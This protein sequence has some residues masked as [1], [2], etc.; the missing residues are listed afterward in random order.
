MI[1][2]KK[3]KSWI[4][5]N[6]NVLLIGKAGV[7]KSSIIKQCFEDNKIN[8]LYFSGATLDPWVD[9]VGIP[10]EKETTSTDG[11]KTS[12]IELVRPKYFEQDEVEAIFIDELNRSHAKVRNAVMELIQFKSINGKKFDKLR[13][14]W[15]AINPDTEKDEN[16]NNVYD[17]ERLDPA[18]KDRFQICYELPYQIDNSYFQSKYGS[19]GSVAT[20]WWTGLDSKTKD[21]VSPRRLEYVLEALNKNIDVRDVLPKQ[22]NVKT[23]IEQIQNGSYEEQFIKLLEEG[24]YEAIISN[25]S[26]VQH[27]SKKIFGNESVLTK[28]VFS[29]PAENFVAKFK[30]FSEQEKRNIETVFSKMISPSII[31]EPE[32]LEYVKNISE[33]IRRNSKKENGQLL[34]VLNNLIRSKSPKPPEGEKTESLSNSTQKMS[35]KDFKQINSFSNLISNANTTG[36]KVYHTRD[37]QTFLEQFDQ[38]DETTITAYKTAFCSVVARFQNG[39]IVKQDVLLKFF[40]KAIE[41]I[42]N[43]VKN[44]KTSS[45]VWP[46]NIYNIHYVERRMKEIKKEIEQYNV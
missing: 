32:K 36:V 27:N 11:K 35:K 6:F 10:K 26:L 23:L 31:V 38:T 9:F 21:V 33:A 14:V 45:I 40:S 44:N 3:L 17:V 1:S 46:K 43:S 5:G 18:L 7:G 29:I 15:A 2:E 16:E 13:F 41:T 20:K 25:D 39:T 22:A 8:H 4:D 28:I 42:E 24:K 19:A 12:Y 37:L 34:A 30:G